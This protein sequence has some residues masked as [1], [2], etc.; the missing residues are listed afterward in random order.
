MRAAFLLLL[1]L[2]A[3]A[4]EVV[5]KP[6]M[7]PVDRPAPP[8]GVAEPCR[9]PE[10]SPIRLPTDAAEQVAARRADQAAA[11]AAIAACDRRRAGAVRVLRRL[12]FD[13]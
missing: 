10:W 5:E 9:A 7:A 13:L 11:A 2:A 1:L 3:C 12:G 6:V 8:P 4:A